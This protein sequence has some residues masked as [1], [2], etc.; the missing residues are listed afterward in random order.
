MHWESEPGSGSRRR[1]VPFER[2]YLPVARGG[3]VRAEYPQVCGYLGQM[4]QGTLPSLR[5]YALS[6]IE[7]EEVLPRLA[8]DR[9]RFDLCEVDVAQCKDAQCL[10]QGAG[11][12]TQ[13]EDNRS[14]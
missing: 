6:E 8:R 14:L 10:E 13:R 5:I 1:G 7:V 4:L 3:S 11:G 9:A 2:V 12:V